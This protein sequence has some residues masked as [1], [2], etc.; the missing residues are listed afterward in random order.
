MHMIDLELIDVDRELANSA[1]PFVALVEC[2]RVNVFD[3][4]IPLARHP[5]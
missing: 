4:L 3:K 2:H 1:R 5:R